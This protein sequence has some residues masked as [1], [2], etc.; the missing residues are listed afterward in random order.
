MGP[1]NTCAGKKISASNKSK[2]FNEK[3]LLGGAAVN[4]WDYGQ[5]E[6]AEVLKGCVTASIDEIQLYSPTDSKLHFNFIGVL[7]G[8][9]TVD[10]Y[11][12]RFSISN[13]FCVE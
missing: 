7:Y 6:G 5:S 12:D 2:N 10:R 4:F 1:G 8:C 13:P 11:R 9:C 3:A